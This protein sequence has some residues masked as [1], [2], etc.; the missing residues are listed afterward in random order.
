MDSTK[1]FNNFPELI[2]DRFYLK[3]IS[4]NYRNDFIE[5]M[6]DEEAMALSGTEVTDVEK[7]VDM[8]FEKV[9]AMYEAKKAIRWAIIDKETGEFSGEIGL[10]NIDFYSNNT[11]VGYTIKRDCWRK[12]IALE[13]SRKVSE[14]AFQEIQMNKIIAMIDSRNRPS[15]KLVEKQG[16]HKDGVL[17]EHYY[18]H[19]DEVYVD[20]C[21]YSLLKKD[22]YWGK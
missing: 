9:K 22:N 5:L 20:I 17:R 21:V 7:Q 15:I 19:K 6:G 18:N 12:G 1:V 16:F 8:Y 13:C 4:L 10:Y 14:F 3:E 2:T 11:E